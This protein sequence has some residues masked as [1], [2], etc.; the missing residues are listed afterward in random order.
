VGPRWRG[1]P[2]DPLGKFGSVCVPRAAIYYPR[3]AILLTVAVRHSR[4]SL[5]NRDL[6]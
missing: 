1:A 5:T 4:S 6:A 2:L 3:F